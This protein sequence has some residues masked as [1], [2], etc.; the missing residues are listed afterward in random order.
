ERGHCERTHYD[1]L[2]R[3]VRV[4]RAHEPVRTLEYDG[5]GYPVR[6]TIGRRAIALGYTGRHVVGTRTEAGTLVRFEY[7]SEDRIEAV[8]NEAGEIW[9]V[10]RDGGG[11]I[12][13]E[14]DFDGTLSRFK[15]DPCGRAIAATRPS[16]ASTQLAYDAMGRLTK[17]TFAD[18][19]SNQYRYG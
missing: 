4:E 17:A 12:V 14:T 6:F 2:G 1:P 8:T 3:E 15:L 10:D 11:R 13:A 9:R 18:G 16:G 7:D 19:T 5:E